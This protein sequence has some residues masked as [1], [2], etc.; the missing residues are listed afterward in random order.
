[1]DFSKELI[2]MLTDGET[3]LDF[4]SSDLEALHGQL[5]IAS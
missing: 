1:M 4:F 2:F 3:G 5:C